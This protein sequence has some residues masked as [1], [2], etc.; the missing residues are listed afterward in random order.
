LWVIWHN[1]A[2]GIQGPLGVLDKTNG[3]EPENDKCD[4]SAVN[5]PL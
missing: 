4:L 3:K 5:R 1:E 2:S